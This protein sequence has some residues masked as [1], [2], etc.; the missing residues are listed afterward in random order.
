MTAAWIGT[1]LGPF[2]STNSIDSLLFLWKG[3]CLKC[4]A[5]NWTK[6]DISLYI[7]LGI[8][9]ACSTF[10]N[11]FLCRLVQGDKDIFKKTI[12]LNCFSFMN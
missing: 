2:N 10:R 9:Y 5:R 8:K 11:K 12:N 4:L 3:M 1:S 7:I 6:T